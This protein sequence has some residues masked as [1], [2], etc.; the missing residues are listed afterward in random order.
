MLC[1]VNYWDGT[2]TKLWY[3]AGQLARLVDPGGE[4]TDFAS[5]SVP[6]W[7]AEPGRADLAAGRRA[8]RGGVAA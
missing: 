1:S 7:G 2:D 6:N 8:C 3:V 4:L 5:A